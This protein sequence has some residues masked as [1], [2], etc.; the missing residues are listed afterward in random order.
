M[1]KLKVLSGDDVV[2]ILNKFGFQPVSQK[3]SHVKVRR[4]AEEGPQSLTV[5]LHKELDKGTIKAIFNQASRYVP[6]QE[7]KFYFYN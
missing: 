3:G 7:L 6:S 5:P 1:P 2:T 4:L